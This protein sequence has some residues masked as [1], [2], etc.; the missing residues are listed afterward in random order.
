MPPQSNSAVVDDEYGLEPAKPAAAGV[1]DDK[2]GLE[3]AGKS[4]KPAFSPGS[5]QQRKGGPVLN[6]NTTGIQDQSKKEVTQNLKADATGGAR[7]GPGP[8]PGRVASEAGLG[9]ASGFSGMPESSTPLKDF[10][11]GLKSQQDELLQHPVKTI[12]KNALFGPAPQLYEMGKG[13]VESGGEIGSGVIHAD[14]E[15]VAHGGGRLVGQL[16]Q[17]G[18]LKESPEAAGN[19]SSVGKVAAKVARDPN[20]GELKPGAVTAGKVGGGIV[21]GVVGGAGGSELLGTTTHP[22]SL[23]G[24]VYGAVQGATAGAALGPTVLEKMIPPRPIYPGAPLPK[25]E[26]F[27]ENHAEDL[28]KRGKEQARIDKTNEGKLKEAEETRQRDLADRG[29]LEMQDATEQSAAIR[30]QRAEE[31]KTAATGGPKNSPVLPGG[32]IVGPEADPLNVKTTY[33]SYDRPKLVEMA[34]KG[35]RNAFEE[36]VRNPAGTDLT[37]FKY[38]YGYGA[39]GNPVYQSTPFR[40]YDYKGNLEAPKRPLLLGKAPVPAGAP[41]TASTAPLN[42]EQTI[43]VPS[44]APIAPMKPPVTENVPRETIQPMEK[45]VGETPEGGCGA[46]TILTRHE[47]AGFYPHGADE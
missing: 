41:E 14:P 5:F 23:P 31:T 35:D 24:A 40:N 4:D 36:L 26:D 30:R 11:T 20:T 45:L 13:L 39:P 22:H 44:E 12:A 43:K 34:R 18:V 6:A 10:G 33:Q 3:P 7:V 21:G 16:A 8:T 28:T 38:Q 2:Y 1:T 32:K 46:P 19:E 17:L 47:R 15:K 25:Y 27:A 42:F 37:Q 29:K 9:A